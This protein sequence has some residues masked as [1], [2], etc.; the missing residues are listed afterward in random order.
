M[1]KRRPEIELRIGALA[2]I[3]APLLAAL[4]FYL[5]NINQYNGLVDFVIQITKLG[6]LTELI[7]LFLVPNLLVFFFFIWRNRIEASKGVIFATLFFGVIMV[8]L[9]FL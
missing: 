7:S 9:K 6:I 3:I 5:Y 1:K 4:A 2:G 8:I